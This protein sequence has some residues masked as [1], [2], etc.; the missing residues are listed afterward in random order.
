M[1]VFNDG[2]MIALAKDR[3]VPSKLPNAWNLKNIFVMGIVYGLYLTLSSWALHHVATKTD[4]FE[5]DF[6][7]FSLNDRDSELEAWCDAAIKVGMGNVPM[8]PVATVEQTDLSICTMDI[9]YKQM[10][11]RWDNYCD[12]NLGCSPTSLGPAC[13][14]GQSEDNAFPSTLQ[15]CKAE[16]LYVRGAMMRSLLYNQVSIS[17]QMLVFVVRTQKY[18]LL[19]R[20]GSLTYIAFFLAQ[21]GAT[22]ISVFGFNGYVEPRFHL[23]DCQFCT[24]STGEDVMFWSDKIV[25]MGLTESVFT[26]SV[27]GCVGYTAVAWVWSIVWYVLLDPIKWALCWLLNEDGFRD[28]D[29]WQKGKERP[30]LLKE[31]EEATVSAAVAGSHGNPL[32]RVSLSKAPAKALDRK[33]ASVVAI[34]RNS[35]TG[36]ARMS[37]DPKKNLQIAR[38]SLVKPANPGSKPGPSKK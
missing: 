22:L 1:A 25:P 16:Q 5:N 4:W 7:L 36:V 20:A 6:N 23:E 10:N 34:T 21:A 9:Y 3:V 17:G 11:E 18:S 14:V 28:M 30:E 31:H 32:G 8:P 13:V 29:A 15:Q 35:K 2:A 37:A 27:L 33:S 26:A 38:N 19:S 24:Y 12:G